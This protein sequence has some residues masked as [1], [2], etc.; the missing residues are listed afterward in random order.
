MP[1]PFLARLAERPKGRCEGL[2]MGICRRW[3]GM[4]VP[5]CQVN[6]PG[7]VD[8]TREQRFVSSYA[9]D[10]RHPSLVRIRR[11]AFLPLRC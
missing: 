1:P 7:S 8:Q 10:S 11:G 5:A 6:F 9:S 2:S 4:A 3:G